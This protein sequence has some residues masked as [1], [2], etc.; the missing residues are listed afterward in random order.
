[1]PILAGLG[2]LGVPELLIIAF[3][4]LLIFGVGRLPEIGGALGKG[5]KEFRNNATDE[6]SAS[7]ATTSAGGDV[8]TPAPEGVPQAA[9]EAS[10]GAVFCSECGA[11]NIDSAKF[12][13]SCGKGLP[14]SVS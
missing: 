7:A 11:R 13:G 8:T 14:A 3:I 12:C 5:I 2:P 10:A 9:S 6:A 4:I 1:M